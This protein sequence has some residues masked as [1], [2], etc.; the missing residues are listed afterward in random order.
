VTEASVA[1]MDKNLLAHEHWVEV[2]TMPLPA[3]ELTFEF[4]ELS[5]EDGFVHAVCGGQVRADE[6]EFLV[7]MIIETLD[8]MP[9]VEPRDPTAV[10]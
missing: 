5:F 9:G 4:F 6:I 8:R 3:R 2:A 10:L 7:G 1:R